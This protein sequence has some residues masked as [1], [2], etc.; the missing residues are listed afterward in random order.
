VS[1]SGA[2]CAINAREG[3]ETI[4]AGVTTSGITE[5]GTVP[6]LKVEEEGL[7]GDVG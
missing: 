3:G 6:F 4:A 2:V 5:G 1:H 7:Q